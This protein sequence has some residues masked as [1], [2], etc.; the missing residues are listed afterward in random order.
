MKLVATYDWY[1]E[2]AAS[3]SETVAIEYS[4]EEQFICD[5]EQWA[6][7]QEEWSDGTFCGLPADAYKDRGN[8]S[9]LKIQ[10]LEDWFEINKETK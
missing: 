2:Y 7:K 6:E 8:C 4:S 10:T 3:G 9:N 5:F 1:V